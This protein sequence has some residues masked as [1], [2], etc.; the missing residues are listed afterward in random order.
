MPLQGS[1]IK[2]LIKSVV[3]CVWLHS[4]G[5]MLLNF[6]HAVASII[7]FLLGSIPLCKYNPL[8][9]STH[10]PVTM[11][12]MWVFPLWGYY[13]WSLY[14]HP[15][16]DLCM[17]IFYFSLMEII[18]SGI[19]GRCA[20][21]TFNFIGNCQTIFQVAALLHFR[22]SPALSNI[23][24]DF[25]HSCGIVSCHVVLF[26]ISLMTHDVEFSYAYNPFTYILWK[27]SSFSIF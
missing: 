10:S 18:R 26:D 5:V 13:E 17:Y 7:V 11:I 16:P 12:D 20:Q 2:G 3:F 4:L 9:L 23:S 1:H 19:A 15:H 22:S 14:E 8:C 24:L 25:S 6:I 27:I 21:C